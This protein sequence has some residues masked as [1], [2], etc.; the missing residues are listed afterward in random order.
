MISPE[1]IDETYFNEVI[2][3]GS[4]I[5]IKGSTLNYIRKHCSEIYMQYSNKY[6]PT[7]KFPSEVNILDFDN[8]TYFR[9]LYFCHYPFKMV[10]GLQLG[11]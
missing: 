10:I 8:N 5:Y 11:D 2:I 3:F 4:N 6:D 1:E 7:A 9:L